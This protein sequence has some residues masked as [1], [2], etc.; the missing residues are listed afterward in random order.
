MYNWFI[1]LAFLARILQNTV[2]TSSKRLVLSVYRFITLRL[3]FLSQNSSSQ[4]SF[5]RRITDSQHLPSQPSGP[6]RA[7]AAP[8]RT[9]RL[10]G[11]AP[12]RPAETPPA[13]ARQHAAPP[14]ACTSVSTCVFSQKPNTDSL[15]YSH[16]CFSKQF[17]ASYLVPHV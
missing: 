14:L 16:D 10:P 11:A 5:Q 12:D 17:I 6:P 13:L 4:F 8:A 15:K 3:I 1:L 9:V 7:A 2:R